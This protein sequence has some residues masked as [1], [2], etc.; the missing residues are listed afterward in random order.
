MKYA[1]VFGALAVALLLSAI[2]SGLWPGQMLLLS[3]ALCFGGVALAYGGVGAK[4]FLKRADGRFPPGSW[5]LFWPY[6]A[7][8]LLA[9]RGFLRR[10]KRS[11]GLISPITERVFLGPRLG[12]REARELL[13]NGEISVLDLAAELPETP[14]LRRARHYLSLPLLDTWAP[15][16]QE[17]RRGAEWIAAREQEGPVYVHCA[18]GHGR[19]ATYVAAFL[20]ASGRASD[21]DAALALIRQQ[22]PGIGLSAAQKRSLLGLDL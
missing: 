18:L 21:V 2:E 11:E 7:L 14:L 13:Q 19:S 17:L 1:L 15:T 22:R 16:P 9:L 6:H 20:L 10:Q 3:G 5:L 8:N 4:T 12:E